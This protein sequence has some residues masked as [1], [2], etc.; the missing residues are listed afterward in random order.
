[1]E[2]R[3]K[4]RPINEWN[5]QERPREKLLERGIGALTDAEIIAL[6]IGSGTRNLSAVDVGQI[7]IERFGGLTGIARADIRALMQTKGIGEAKAITLSAAFE[8]AKRK[9]LVDARE[10]KVTDSK[11]VAA[12]LSPRFMDE[13]REVFYVLFLNNNLRVVLED[14]LFKGGV[15]SSVVDV[16]ILMKK[17]IDCLATSIIVSHNH[18]SGNLEPSNADISITQKIKQSGEILDIRL[19]DHL[20]ISSQGYYSFADHGQI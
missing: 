9:Q 20:I 6:L 5:H 12:Y 16:R 2:E 10:F 11:S 17:A 3:H 13:K 7:M 15:T 4:N 14:D 19:L 8:I 1:V 18:P